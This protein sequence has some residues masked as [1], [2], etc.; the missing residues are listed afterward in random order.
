MPDRDPPDN[1]KLVGYLKRVAAELHDARA[2]LRRIEER[3]TEPVAIVA[4]ACRFPGGVASPED[5]WRLVAEGRDAIGPLPTD[6]GWDV[7]GLDAVTESR[8]RQGG[9]LDRV[10]DFDPEFFGISPREA[11]AMDPQQRVLLEVG[12]E[13]FE[14]AGLDRAAVRGSRTGVF[15]GGGWTG[16]GSDLGEV[17]DGVG[18]HLATG[19]I[20][21]VLSGRLAFLYGLEGP[22]VTVDT[23]CSSSLVALHLA[24][25]ALRGG[26]C[27]MALAGGVTVMPHMGVFGASGRQHGMAPDGRCKAFGAG[28]DGTGWSEGAGLL[29]LQRLS[30]ARRAGRRVLAVVRGSA[31]NQDGAGSGLT[32]PNGSAQRRVIRQAL[33]DARLTPDDI[34]AVEASAT[35]TPLGDPI[36]ARALLAGYGSG[37]DPR[38]P[39]W[40]GSLK[41]NVGHTQSAAG[42]AGVIKTVMALRHGVLPKTLH[43]DEPTPHVDW[44][45]GT[46]RLLTEARPWPDTGERPRRAGV[47]SFG[48]SGT[49]AHVVVEQAPDEPEF[50]PERIAVVNRPPAPWVLSARDEEGLRAQAERLAARVTAEPDLVPDD[51]AYSLATTRTA[52]ACR[53]AVTA[54]DLDGFAAR[55]RALAAGEGTAVMA[56]RDPRPV[57]VFPD[58]GPS[59]RT[60]PFR[61]LLDMSP[62][63]AATIAECQSALDPWVGWS[64]AE[65]LRAADERAP[66][67]VDVAEP[68][69]WAVAVALAR[70]W[71]AHGVQPAAVVGHGHGEIAAACVAGG[72]TLADGAKV[73]ALRGRAL[74]ELAGTGGMVAGAVS[75]HAPNTP[76]VEA[77]RARL[78]RDL[79]DLA[80]MPATVPFHSSTTGTPA[81]TA[82]LD[83]DHWYGNPWRQVRFD[84]AV[85]GL[86]SEGH[87]VFVEIGAQP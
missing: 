59:Y 53:A 71:Q 24:V 52:L 22:A 11:L 79:A 34:D 39:L 7:D 62:E 1:H 86:S 8:V 30:D 47:S 65:L 40:L 16:Y 58:H 19:T 81:D 15:V 25:R 14:R 13:L 55:L 54:A 9:F 60:D 2:E 64:I 10:A 26:E 66:T 42:V 36:E 3:D 70:L 33:A 75:D 45:A 80:P 72:L 74:H 68:L 32:T 43:V 4:M 82:V 51:V 46:V 87:N 61:E 44:S 73:A 76:H 27:T 50:E 67:R 57:F 21:S 12:W 78:T 31:V 6:R 23:A 18:D 38:Q 69:S 35:G 41:S 37:R 5:L 56:A 20:I 83:A 49:N 63:F 85:G 17:P 48:I 28:A 29:L 84:D 77:I